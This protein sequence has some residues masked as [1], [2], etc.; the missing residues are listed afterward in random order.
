MLDT[1]L[2]WPR[3]GTQKKVF[4]RQHT[5]E[6]LTRR[7]EGNI[8]T[9]FWKI[10]CEIWEAGGPGLGPS[11]PAAGFVTTCVEPSRSAAGEL[12]GGLARSDSCRGICDE[13]SAMDILLT[14]L[15]F[16]EKSGLS[17]LHCTSVFNPQR[18]VSGTCME[19]PKLL[20]QPS[21][22]YPNTSFFFRI[23]EFIQPDPSLRQDKGH[24]FF[25]SPRVH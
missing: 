22:T 4:V 5:R 21:V 24:S 13:Q 19:P 14:S 11:C 1:R 23:T 12:I 15:T 6:T 9:Y 25:L 16:A 17:A 20:A 7:E 3:Q 8:E 10:Y 2:G 18:H